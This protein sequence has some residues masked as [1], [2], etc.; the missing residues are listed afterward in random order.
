MSPLEI[1]YQNRFNHY[2][3][4]GLDEEEAEFEALGDYYKNY[5]SIKIL[6]EIN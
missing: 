5:S 2:L 6:F 4:V 3:S 1:Y